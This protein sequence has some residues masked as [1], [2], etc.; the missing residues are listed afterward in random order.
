MARAAG[1]VLVRLCGVLSQTGTR[2]AGVPFAATGGRRQGLG[3]EVSDADNLGTA[4]EEGQR[5]GGGAPGE[6]A[7]E[8][9]AG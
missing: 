2:V 5:E 9:A 1:D 6:P 3:I 8:P 7:D 4:F